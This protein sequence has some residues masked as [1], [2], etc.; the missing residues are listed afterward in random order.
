MKD[1]VS[2]NFDCVS[3]SLS[4]AIVP[5][6]ID[7]LHLTFLKIGSLELSCLLFISLIC[8]LVEV[9]QLLG[10]VR[11]NLILCQNVEWLDLRLFIHSLHKFRMFF[12]VD[13]LIELL[14]LREMNDLSMISTELPFNRDIL[15][16][17]LS[18]L[19]RF[20]L[21]NVL[22]NSFWDKARLKDLFIVPC[23]D[24]FNWHHRYPLLIVCIVARIRMICDSSLAFFRL[25]QATDLSI[26]MNVRVRN[27]RHKIRIIR[28]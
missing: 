18:L 17:H 24:F 5:R 20:D 23:P 27:T 4:S 21:H 15:Y 28:I 10:S 19:H 12:W 7:F 16:F 2:V 6:G 22:F 8:L 11:T 1:G 3:I 14:V 25:L 26:R 9:D 13:D